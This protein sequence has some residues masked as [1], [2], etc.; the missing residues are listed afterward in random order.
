MARTRTRALSAGDNLE[1]LSRLESGSVALV[2]LDPPFASGRTYDLVN[3]HRAGNSGG[4]TEA[5]KDAWHSSG[6]VEETHNRL[7]QLVPEDVAETVRVLVRSL[8]R[9]DLAAYLV[10]MA[11]RLVELHRVLDERGSLYLHCDPAASHYLKVLLDQ[12]FGPGNFRNDIIWKRTHAHSSS[13]RFGPVHDTL[14]FY[15]KSSSYTWNPPYAAYADGYLDRYYTLEDAR[16]RYQLITCTAPGDRPGT[17]AH[18]EWRGMLP[19]PGRHWAWK[20]ERM[21]EL[22]RDGRLAHSANGIPRLKRY[23]D[24]APG[25]VVQDIWNDINRLDAHS[26]ERVGFET[27]KPLELLERII[28]ASSN[29]G[30]TVLDPFTGSGTTIV[31]AERLERGWIGIDQSLLA[32]SIALSRVRQDVNVSRVTL[33]GFPADTRSAMTLRRTE[34]VAFGMWGASMLATL[35]GRE[36]RTPNLIT[37]KGRLKP[38]SKVVQ[39]MSWVPLADK[40]EPTIPPVPH[41]RLSKL[42]IVLRA[43][44]ADTAFAGTIRSRLDIPIHELG[45]DELVDSASR[46]RG[47]ASEL[48]KL[49]ES[50]S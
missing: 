50:P 17:K 12:I 43:D 22:E 41:G 32:C 42:G 21:E 35:A 33:A 4:R 48:V 11:P 3:R 31:A 20:E 47:M 13:R 40:V 5:F 30:D 8:G 10:M 25:V 39:L 19:P 44:R 24:D 23:V 37:G 45:L 18:Y 15:S 9:R 16:G 1:E 28:R 49:A 14:L 2:Y 6:P 34:P 7:R 46:S 36:G 26:D 38:G 29:P 27:Q